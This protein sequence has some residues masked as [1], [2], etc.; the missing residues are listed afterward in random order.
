VQGKLQIDDPGQLSLSGLVD[1]VGFH[2]LTE[3]A[4]K[5]ARS[6]RSG[7]GTRRRVVGVLRMISVDAEP[8]T[9]SG[10]SSICVAS[11]CS[12]RWSRFVGGGP[13]R[14][15]LFPRAT[16]SPLKAATGRVSSGRPKVSRGL[17]F[18]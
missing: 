11:H 9:L 7:L 5:G 16:E 13:V 15:G 8:D 4:G 3:P 18:R 17:R 1:G 14:N 12:A 2:R 6:V 10:R